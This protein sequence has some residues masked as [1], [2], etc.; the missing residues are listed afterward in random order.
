MLKKF[1]SIYLFIG[2]M[3]LLTINSL[4][5]LNLYAEESLKVELNKEL[6][7]GNFLIGLK[8]Y[9]GSE[10][11]SFSKNNYITFSTDEGFLNLKTFNGIKHKARKINIIWKNIP[12]N[13]PYTFERLVF[14]PYASYESAQKK[15]KNLREKGF[16]ATVAYPENWEVWTPFNKNNLPK[17]ESN[18][19]TLSKKSFTSQITPFLTTDF[20]NT[21][22]LEGP[23][24]IYADKDI[25]INNI[26][27]G[28]KFFL[29][30][31]SY[32]TWTLIQK[33]KFDEY[34][35]G[36]LP[37][38]I[39]ANSPLE[40]LKAQAVIA[41]TWA[42]YNS[43][44]FNMDKYHL[45]V[46]TQCQVYKPPI[47]LNKK[48][49]DAI[50][51]TSN[52]VITHKGKPI[53]SFYHGASGGIS[54]SAS[55]SWKIEDFMYLKTIIDS[56]A[57]LRKSVKLPLDNDSKVNH[58]LDFF[59]KRMYGDYHPFFR[60]DKQIS[61]LIIIDNLIKNNLIKRN[62]KVLNINVIERG[63]SGR[64]TKLE[65]ELDKSKKPIL[66]VKDDIRRILRF[67]P[68]NLFTINKLSDNLWHFRGG[69]FGHGVGLSQSGA[70]EMAKQG[71]TYEQILN[72][73]YKGIKLKKIEIMSQ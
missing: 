43:Q 8:Q 40:A 34:L 47:V 62:T 27:F 1:Q 55:E 41:R 33:L 48:V 71:F 3:F 38:E 36:V 49:K 20:I 24:Y 66:L 72:H 37:H 22:K 61:N 54:A 19:Y 59:G 56:P 57:S 45:C 52:L 23:I 9:L 21:K 10:N 2:C 58:F 46:T 60:W 42:I 14:G 67:L 7:K 39:G 44:R 29:A 11:D 5:I 32:G 12:I 69:G 63:F 28:K 70:I 25:K 68:S 64:V 6:K 35:E 4:F 26:N 65:I 13:N 30:K 15:A 17:N 51:Q 53:N 50:K 16:E 31:D 18:K 73:Y